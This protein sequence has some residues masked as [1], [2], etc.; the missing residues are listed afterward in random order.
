M[1]IFVKEQRLN[2]GGCEGRR[3]VCSQT[4]PKGIQIFPPRLEIYK[5][6]IGCSG[7]LIFSHLLKDLS[8]GKVRRC[9]SECVTEADSSPHPEEASSGSLFFQWN[10][11]GRRVSAVFIPTERGSNCPADYIFMQLPFVSRRC[12]RWSLAEYLDRVF[13]G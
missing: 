3:K 9:T 13:I 7:H 4:H 11:V 5:L 6:L 10:R 8:G 12:C 1:W 2:S